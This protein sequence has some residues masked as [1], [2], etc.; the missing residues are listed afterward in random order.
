MGK[1]PFVITLAVILCSNLTASANLTFSKDSIIA[2]DGIPQ[3]LNIRAE[4]TIEIKNVATKKAVIDS[5]KIVLPE[6]QYP[7]F[8]IGW[9]VKLVSKAS[10]CVQVF[11]SANR[12]TDNDCLHKGITLT[13]YTNLPEK[14]KL[15]IGPNSKIQIQSPYVSTKCSV[16]DLILEIVG[17]YQWEIIN[18]A[19]KGKISFF[20]NNTEYSVVL[21]ITL[22]N[23]ST[24]AIS[25][26][27][28]INKQTVLRSPQKT[29]TLLGRTCNQNSKL[30]MYRTIK[31][32]GNTNNAYILK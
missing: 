8:Q 27:N 14:D 2:F 5:I 12:L 30:Q 9:I 11:N 25:Q 1:H 4:D 3:N 32:K 13:D 17:P 16:V 21:N 20:S 6:N 29:I 15:S 18:R 28:K 26:N 10:R 22:Y 19:S 31:S 7:E 24:S 23:R